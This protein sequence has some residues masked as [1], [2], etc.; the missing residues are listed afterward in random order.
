MAGG[1]VGL[2]ELIKQIESY[3]TDS[4]SVVAF[5]SLS[6]SGPPR[7]ARSWKLFG[8]IPPHVFLPSAAVKTITPSAAWSLTLL[9]VSRR[10]QA[11]KTD[12]SSEL[13]G[14]VKRVL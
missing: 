11:L 13:S 7:W 5:S 3:P 10:N 14:G 6:P 4:K 2:S 9:A 1:R 12:A 8:T